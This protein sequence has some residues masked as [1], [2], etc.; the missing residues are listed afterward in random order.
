MTA[1][2]EEYAARDLLRA[3]ADETRAAEQ[4]MRYER[5]RLTHRPEYQA[6]LAMLEACGADKRRAFATLAEYQRTAAQAA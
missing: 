2:G 3:L 5:Q 1:R 6:A 4:V